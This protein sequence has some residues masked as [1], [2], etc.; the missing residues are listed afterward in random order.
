MEGYYPFT[1][2]LKHDLQLNEP[3]QYYC[4][5]KG[6]FPYV[7]NPIVGPPLGAPAFSILPREVRSLFLR[8]FV[9]GQKNLQARPSPREWGH[10]LENAEKNLVACT[11]PTRN[12][13]IRGI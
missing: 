12:T 5:K 11:N 9:A 6:A 1:G 10:V 7:N 13:I 3:A 8:C 2:V 4:L